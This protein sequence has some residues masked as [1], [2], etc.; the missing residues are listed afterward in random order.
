MTP[1]EAFLMFAMIAGVAFVLVVGLVAW[2]RV[3]VARLRHDLYV[4]MLGTG[5]VTKEEME[6]MLHGVGAERSRPRSA[7]VANQ[8]VGGFIGFLV[9]VGWMGVMVAAGLGIA[10]LAVGASDRTGFFIAAAIL[11]A[12]SFGLVGLP[13]GLRELAGRGAASQKSAG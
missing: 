11:G 8:R 2:R 3:Q 10:G 4:K 1:H 12:V 6:E 13:V 7:P 9:G 5:K